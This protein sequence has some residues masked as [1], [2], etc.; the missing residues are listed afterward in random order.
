[1][2]VSQGG[3]KV[4]SGFNEMGNSTHVYEINQRLS[5][6]PPFSWDET[7]QKGDVSYREWL[8]EVQC[9]LNDPNIKST[10]IQCIHRSL[11]GT[12]KKMLIPLGEKASVKDIL[13]KLDI[14]FG[15]VSDNGMIM[16]D[17]FIA[18]Q[19]SDENATIFGCRSENMLQNAIDNGYLD[20][21]AKNDLLRHTLCTSLSSD[22]LLSQTR[23]KYNT[24]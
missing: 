19:K 6:I 24:I 16:E 15:E 11:R 5:T 7:P 12:A 20:R 2:S 21:A 9:L 1:M 14:L 10:L 3:V 18:F 23:H 4:A 13:D 17:F 22:R 8:Y